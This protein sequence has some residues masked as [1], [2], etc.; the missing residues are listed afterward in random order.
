MPLPRAAD[1]DAGTAVPQ[2]PRI[3]LGT[4]A[5]AVGRGAGDALEAALADAFVHPHF[6][7]RHGLFLVVSDVHEGA[8][9]G[10]L[11][12]PQLLLHRPAQ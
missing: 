10:A 7:E 1:G 4:Q 9:L 6:T 3:H 8:A 5:H 2:G 11:E 12:A